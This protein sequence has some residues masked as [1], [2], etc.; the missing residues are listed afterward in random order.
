VKATLD[1]APVASNRVGEPIAVEPGAR[2]VTVT[3]PSGGVVRREVTVAAG[4]TKTLALALPGDGP[5]ADSTAPPSDTGETSGGGAR[6]V[7]FAVAGLGVA[8]MVVFGVAGVMAQGKFSTLETECGGARCT[9]PKYAD[10]VDSGKTLDTIANIGLIAGA[11]C[12]A[13]GGAMIIFGGPS[14]KEPSASAAVT[15]A[16]GGAAVRGTVAF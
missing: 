6:I 13:I 3:A 2:V 8:G 16:P 12:L 15:L 4:E 9:D 11:S 7:G 14:A 10:V 5:R 1:G